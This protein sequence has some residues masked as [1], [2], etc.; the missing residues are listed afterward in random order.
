MGQSRH[1]PKLGWHAAIVTGAV[2]LFVVTAF[3]VRG[4]HVS[5]VER[6]LF[7]IVND[8]PAFLEGPVWLVMQLGNGVMVVV[9]PIVAALCRR[10]R[11]AATLAGAGIA[12]YLLARY[13]KDI[14]VRPR[15]GALLHNVHLRPGSTSQGHGFPSGHAAVAFAL[16]TVL[17]LMIGPKLRPFAMA[18][19]LLG[20]AIV[21][22]G[23]VYV[24]AHFPF[25]VVG[26][27]ALGIVVAIAA[28]A[29]SHSIETHE[30]RRH[31]LWQAPR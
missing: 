7:R 18:L 25:D 10:F 31:R 24:G 6:R 12:A 17:C 21:G 1:R 27:A 28:V 5:A 20:A 11:L 16:A 29:V 8:L 23:R 30:T 2:V 13:A 15:P 9:A 14:V 4:Q 22:F 26:G 3:A 19:I